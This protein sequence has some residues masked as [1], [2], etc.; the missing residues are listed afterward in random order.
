MQSSR[1][2]ER[3]CLQAQQH[4]PPAWHRVTPPLLRDSKGHV[5]SRSC[6]VQGAGLHPRRQSGGV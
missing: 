1:E 6:G 5:G 3:Q 4:S 2:A